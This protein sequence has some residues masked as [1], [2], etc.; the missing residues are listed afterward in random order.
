MYLSLTTLLPALF[1]TPTET[2]ETVSLGGLFRETQPTYTH[3]SKGRHAYGIV[4]YLQT[5]IDQVMVGS[6]LVQREKLFLRRFL[7]YIGHRETVA[8]AALSLHRKTRFR[9]DLF[10]GPQSIE[11]SSGASLQ[12]CTLSVLCRRWQN[13]SNIVDKREVRSGDLSISQCWIVYQVLV[14]GESCEICRRM[15]CISKGLLFIVVLRRI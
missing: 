2:P 7:E 5:H 15:F 4:F 10:T 9:Q 13:I 12:R 1:I 14:L 8:G 3:T 11:M 6:V